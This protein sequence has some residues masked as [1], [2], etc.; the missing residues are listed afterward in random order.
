[1]GTRLVGPVRRAL[2]ATL[3]ALKELGRLEAVDG[4]LVALCRST[5]S[6]VDKSPERAA[7][8]KEYRECLVLLASLGPDDGDALDDLLAALRSPVG[9]EAES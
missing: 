9:D 7:L 6:A 8:V 5:A 4:A 3:K 1:M 2:D